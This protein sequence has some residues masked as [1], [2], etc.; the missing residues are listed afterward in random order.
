MRTNL[1]LLSVG[2][3]LTGC[4]ATST[5][6][7]NV[8]K[9][10][11]P[12]PQ[13]LEHAVCVCN[14]LSQIGELHVAAGPAGVGSVGVNGKTDLVAKADVAGSWTAWGGFSTVGASIGEDLVTPADV[15]I[16]G[17]TTISGDAVIGGNLNATGSLG[18]TGALS[19]GGT[20]ELLGDSAIAAR[21][22]YAGAGSAPPCGCDEATMFDV[23]AAVAA[24]RSATG[25]QPSWSHVGKSDLHL[26]TG[27]YYVTATEIVG[28]A[29]IHID[30]NVSIFVDGSLA[31]VG[32]SQWQISAGGSL[33]LFVA[34]NVS[35]VGDLKVGDQ[36]R[37]GAFRLFVGGDHTTSVSSIGTTGFYG[38]LYA[39]RASVSYI[40]DAH[41]VGS[42]FARNLEGVGRLTIEYGA[43]Q[44]APES[45]EQPPAPQPDG[46][47]LL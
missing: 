14:D 21:T 41:I 29:A 4:T 32:S 38:S 40:G 35:S 39:P 36:G 22:P 30:G 2:A 26:T 45:C 24:A 34:G 37:P 43:P 17:A 11:C 42:I 33:D 13:L 15:E 28:E 20:E 19:V 25:G 44:T 1:L 8:A 47:I 6:S 7:V 18:V 5:E 27:T 46:P 23:E 16:V 10:T 31:S 9:L 12:P 3:A